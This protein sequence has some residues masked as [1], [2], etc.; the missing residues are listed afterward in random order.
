[1]EKDLSVI[2]DENV[3]TTPERILGQGYE[4]YHSSNMDI[5]ITRDPV[6]ICSYEHSHEEYEF[7][8]PILYT[9]KQVCFK[10]DSSTVQPTPGSLI[11]ANPGQKHGIEDLFTIY[12]SISIFVQKQYMQ[13][14]AYSAAGVRTE[15]CFLC[16]FTEH[17]HFSKVLKS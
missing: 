4:F 6:K 12:K 9:P 3:I 15:I 8:I 17:S 1:M 16:G 5:M 2:A 7:F 10:I 14:A 13:Q 11:P